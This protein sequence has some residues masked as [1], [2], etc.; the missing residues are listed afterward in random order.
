MTENYLKSGES[1]VRIA[2]VNEDGEDG[3]GGQD[4]PADENP[5]ETDGKEDKHDDPE[6]K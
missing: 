4:E 1:T 3:E 2:E 6:E 5:S